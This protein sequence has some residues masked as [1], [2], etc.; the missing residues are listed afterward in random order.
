M[1]KALDDLERRSGVEGSLQASKPSVVDD[2]LVEGEKKLHVCKV[3]GGIFIT[4]ATYHFIAL[5]LLVIFP[6]MWPVSFLIIFMA[7]YPTIIALIRYKTTYL[8]LTN[9][10]VFAR[11]G[12][13]NRDNIQVRI[14]KIESAFLERPLIGQML[15]YGTVVIRG[16][17]TG[18]IPIPFIDNGQAFVRKLEK[19]TLETDE[20][21]NESEEDG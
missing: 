4:P 21:K 8:V 6:R 10:R 19:F 9:K 14:D 13:F 16:T 5:L 15:G 7:L 20:D 2:Q 18:A 17:G 1:N 11:Y 12:F 3:H